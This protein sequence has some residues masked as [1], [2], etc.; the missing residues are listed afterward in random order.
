MEGLP[1]TERDGTHHTT[2]LVNPPGGE[3][4][5]AGHVILK[6]FSGFPAKLEDN[7]ASEKDMLRGGAAMGAGY[8]STIRLCDGKCSHRAHYGCIVVIGN[9]CTAPTS[10]TETRDGKSRTPEGGKQ[11]TTFETRYPPDDPGNHNHSLES[12]KATDTS[13]GRKEEP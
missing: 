13:T 6:L 11:T 3:N 4:H 8:N 10:E 1:T 9:D 12:T 5:V 2:H 7:F